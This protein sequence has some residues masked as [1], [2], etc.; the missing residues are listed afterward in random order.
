MVCERE[1][2]GIAG[3][4]TYILKKVDSWHVAGCVIMPSLTLERL[5]KSLKPG[6][7]IPDQVLEIFRN[8]PI[9]QPNRNPFD[10]YGMDQFKPTGK[11]QG[12]FGRALP[13]FQGRYLNPLTRHKFPI[14]IAA[15]N[16]YAVIN[17]NNIRLGLSP[18]N[19]KK[20]TPPQCK[21]LLTQH[22]CP[23]GRPRSRKFFGFTLPRSIFGRRGGV[24]L[25]ADE[26]FDPAFGSPL[27]SPHLGDPEQNQMYKDVGAAA[28]REN[29][30]CNTT[31]NYQS[32]TAKNLPWYAGVGP[33][34]NAPIQGTADNCWLIAALSAIAWT[35]PEYYFPDYTNGLFVLNTDSTLNPQEQLDGSWIIPDDTIGFNGSTPAWSRSK[36]NELWVPMLERVFALRE[37]YPDQNFLDDE[38]KSQETPSVC[39]YYPGDP[40][41]AL[42]KLKGDACYTRYINM[43]PDGAGVAPN[44]QWVNEET[45][46]VTLSRDD[47]WNIL[48]NYTGIK[49]TPENYFHKTMW[50]TVA[51]TFQTEDPQV[52]IINHGQVDPSLKN[53]PE[54]SGVSYYGQ[55]AFVGAHA[56]TVLGTFIDP[57]PVP[58]TP[59]D[60]NNCYVL[61]RNPWGEILMVDKTN[62][63]A[64]E[65]ST[66][67]TI[68]GFGPLWNG[69]SLI[70]G[71]FAVKLDRFYR[72]FWGLSYV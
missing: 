38:A 2:S 5:Q 12:F 37:Q 65:M 70:D 28:Q 48:Y 43:T 35:D 13:D 71:V 55:D 63:A 19:W 21:A 50:A 69:T 60:L 49:P 56:Y 22:L 61:L 25:K 52:T 53:A 20:V 36:F 26:L 66:L 16:P 29:E 64:Y 54:Y 31:Y 18:I 15:K 33:Q 34:Y 59:V 1:Y 41:Y 23:I 30:S 11:T 3:C 9:L 32:A 14:H 67:N 68:P 72:Y 8:R 42:Y 24:F 27:F 51:W 4:G 57:Q 10:N 39:N 40:Q 62:A 6:L 44:Y 7:H 46:A 47:L 45:P 58:N 17:R